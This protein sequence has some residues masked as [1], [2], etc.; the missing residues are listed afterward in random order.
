MNKLRMVTITAAALIALPL[1][2]TA[3]DTDATAP[4]ESMNVALVVSI[5]PPALEPRF[6]Q[7]APAAQSQDKNTSAQHLQNKSRM[8]DPVSSAR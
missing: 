4:V 1:C 8:R 2:A 5:K 7:P 6:K 3:G